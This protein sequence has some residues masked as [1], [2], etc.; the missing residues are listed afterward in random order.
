VAMTMTTSAFGTMPQ[1]IIFMDLRSRERSPA[2]A[3]IEHARYFAN[4]AH[5]GTHIF[6][7]YLRRTP[8][9]R[10]EVAVTAGKIAPLVD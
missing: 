4:I 8:A 6:K 7:A 1:P 5:C 2:F 9:F 3:P 10:R